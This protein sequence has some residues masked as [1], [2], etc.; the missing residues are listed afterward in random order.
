MYSMKHREMTQRFVFK[1]RANYIGQIIIR[2][3]LLTDEYWPT[4]LQVN[5]SAINNQV[6]TN[7]SNIDIKDDDDAIARVNYNITHELLHMTQ[8]EADQHDSL[9]QEKCIYAMIGNG[10]NEYF[11]EYYKIE[12]NPT[13]DKLTKSEV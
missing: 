6:N 2:H 12:K 10:G 7:N 1:P 8:H 4:T 9:E 11:N 13:I 3:N 5:L